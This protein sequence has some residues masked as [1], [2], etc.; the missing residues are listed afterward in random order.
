MLEGAY[1]LTVRL[2]KLTN[3][4][5]I[6]Q[7]IINNLLRDLIEIGDIVVFIDD[8]MVGT[9]IEKRHNDIVKE[10]LRKIAENNLFVKLEKCM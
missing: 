2:F 8:V 10:I 3:S 5:A 9:E 4:L 6:F 1:K 7:A